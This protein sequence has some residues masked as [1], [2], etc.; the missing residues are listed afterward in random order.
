MLPPSHVTERLTPWFTIVAAVIAASWALVQYSN[1]LDIRR[2]SATLELHR[3]YRVD[4]ASDLYDLIGGEKGEDQKIAIIREARC[5]YYKELIANGGLNAAG[6]TLPDCSRVTAADIPVL[7]RLGLTLDECQRSE[8]RAILNQKLNASTKISR[9][10]F[11]Q[12]VGFFR[13]VRLCVDQSTCDAGTTLSLFEYDVV[14][15]LNASCAHLEHDPTRKAEAILLADFVRKLGTPAQPYWSNDPNQT[16]PFVC[17]Y[18]REKTCEA[19]R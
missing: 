8:F 18:L 11:G 17:D 16:D 19:E 9:L 10:K 15:F 7:D 4:H 1:D 6:L 14:S 12:I 5:R 13:S 2:V 3:Q